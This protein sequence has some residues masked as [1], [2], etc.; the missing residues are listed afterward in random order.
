MVSALLSLS[1]CSFTHPPTHLPKPQNDGGQQHEV[2]SRYFRY[3]LPRFQ[4]SGW[5]GGWVGEISLL[6]A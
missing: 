1:L 3:L 6:S 4:V 5:V 2:G